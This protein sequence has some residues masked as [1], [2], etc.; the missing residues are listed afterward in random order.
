MLN[1]FSWLPSTTRVTKVVLGSLDCGTN[2]IFWQV[3]PPVVLV[4]GL[5]SDHLKRDNSAYVLIDDDILVGKVDLFCCFQGPRHVGF[6]G[7]AMSVIHVVDNGTVVAL[8]FFTGFLCLMVLACCPHLVGIGCP[9][10]PQF[11]Q[12]RS[13][14]VPVFG[15][16]WSG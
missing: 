16:G 15:L 6:H 7:S 5:R 3:F 4:F 2:G 11:Q 10:V 12:Q 14:V 8:L 13:V 1:A 9:A